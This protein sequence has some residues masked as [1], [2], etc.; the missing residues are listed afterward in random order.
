LATPI[1]TI[2]NTSMAGCRYLITVL[3]R[4]TNRQ[5]F[6]LLQAEAETL[7]VT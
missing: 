2:V 3:K 6:M 1:S 4:L 5:V 7:S